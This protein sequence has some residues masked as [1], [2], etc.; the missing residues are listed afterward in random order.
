MGA[1]LR[2][3]LDLYGS[4]ASPVRPGAGL[5]PLRLPA[6]RPQKWRDKDQSDSAPAAVSRHPRYAMTVSCGAEPTLVSPVP[7]AANSAAVQS[8]LGVG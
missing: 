1:E 6:K 4:T 7:V 2:Q 8:A 5:R 3:L